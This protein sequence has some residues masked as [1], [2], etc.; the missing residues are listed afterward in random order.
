MPK[1][2]VKKKPPVPRN[3]PNFDTTDKIYIPG[4]EELNEPPSD[5]K[6]YVLC[7]YG[8]KSIGKSTIASES[9]NAFTLMS[10]P[11]RRG[12]RLRMEQLKTFTAEEILAGSPD[13]YLRIKNTIPDLLDN[14][15]VQTL[16]FDSI[17]LFYDMVIHHISA[18]NGVNSPGKAGKSSADVWIEVRNEFKSF[19]DTLIET[20]LRI[21]LLSHSKEREI[22]GLDGAPIS[23]VGP[24]C[25]PACLA[26]IKQAVDYGFFYGF[27][28]SER[29]RVMVIRDPSNTVWT[30]CGPEG[31]FLQP[32]GKPIYKLEMPN[33]VG[34]GYQTLI[35]A[36]NNQHWD[37][38]TPEE[39]RTTTPKKPLPRKLPRR[40]N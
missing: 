12:L 18:K 3:L 34:K 8:M 22:E 29:K 39:E 33:T 2:T 28:A 25:A 1:K 4:P 24:S 35:E 11:L 36:F 38:D 23:L 9:E 10:E 30:G 16:V 37:L 40:T 15:S 5:F 32:D 13:T 21:I 20:R 7:I 14:D 27:E 17:D 19:M 6:D 26:Y 31:R